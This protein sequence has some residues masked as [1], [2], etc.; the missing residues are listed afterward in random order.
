MTLT[1]LSAGL[2]T[3]TAVTVDMAG[4][5]SA[6][7]DPLG[8]TVDLTPPITPAW[9]V[10][11]S[12]LG[13]ATVTVTG[14]SDPLASVQISRA[15]Q[16][17]LPI[18]VIQTD[19]TGHF[20]FTNVAVAAGQNS[21]IVTA[22]DAAGNTASFAGSYFSLVPDTSPPKVTARLDHDTGVSAS[23]GITNDATIVGTVIAASRVTALQASVNG[24]P[25]VSIL[26][27]L[28]GANFALTRS[29]LS[30]ILGSS[31]GD[32]AVRVQVTATSASGATSAPVEVDYTLDT[33][34]P[35]TPD[36]L[37]M[38]AGSV[39]VTSLNSFATNVPALSIL[40]GLSTTSASVVL[41]ANGTPVSRAARQ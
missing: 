7:S 17:D 37:H 29:V 3:V 8:I 9:T 40:T 14:T 35:P 21:F 27:T 2:H 31:L 13:A 4:N 30:T 23:D 24:G 41:Y 12:G 22:S 16:A 19:A 32:G 15:S 34:R 10:S 5:R 36:Q 28:S 25:F 6:T 38:P 39:H 20:T 18:A 26:G 33:A 11:S 1:P